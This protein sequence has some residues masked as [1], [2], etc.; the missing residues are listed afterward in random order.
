MTDI[1]TAAKFDENTV[2]SPGVYVHESSDKTAKY[3]DPE[4]SISNGSKIFIPENTAAFIYDQSGIT[5]V[6]AEPGQY[7]YLVSTSDNTAQKYIAFVN[8]REITKFALRPRGSSE[9]YDKF[10]GTNLTII[11]FGKL[12]FRIVDPAKFVQNFQR[13]S[14]SFHDFF[15][16]VSQLEFSIEF[17]EAFC[18]A[19]SSLS[20]N[21]RLSSMRSETDA[22]IRMIVGDHSTPGSWM[23]RYGLAIT[24]LQISSLEYMPRSVEI[25][26]SLAVETEAGADVSSTL[27][28]QID[29]VK[30]L[31]ELLDAGILT[32]E[33]FAAKKKQI[34][35]I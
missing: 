7:E 16:S 21:H 6:I 32:Q 19:F 35:A 26:E 33:E 34:L 24:E 31:K 5:D 20:E 25:I 17:N 3:N 4:L 13:E 15:S 30:K 27:D 11:W 9:Y 22:I 12:S 10:Y 28:E 29:A 14:T 2:V 1:V 23:N 8:L 18:A